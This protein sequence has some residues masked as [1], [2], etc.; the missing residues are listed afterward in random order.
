MATF[1]SMLI[2]RKNIV[3]ANKYN[4][5]RKIGGGS[6]GDIY[7]AVNSCGGEVTFVIFIDFTLGRW[8]YPVGLRVLLVKTMRYFGIFGREDGG[9]GVFLPLLRD[10]GSPSFSSVK[11]F[12]VFCPDFVYFVSGTGRK[13][14]IL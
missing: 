5:V 4:V 9:P 2:N 7:L 14:H 1:G 8:S 3:I 12:F 10:T 13:L 11:M 6:F